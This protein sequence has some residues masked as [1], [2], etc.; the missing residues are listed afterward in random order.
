MKTQHAVV[1]GLAM[2]F[3]ALLY[4]W[5]LYPAL[6]DRIPVHWNIHGQVDGWAD[7]RVAI[8]LMPGVMALLVGMLVAL[9]WLSP[10]N[11]AIE[12]FGGTF[13]AMLL[14]C[15]ALVGF[16]HGVM[17]QA[18]LHPEMDSGRVL[19]IG[20][21]VF[22]ALLGSGLGR[23]RRNFWIGIRT[24]WTLASDAVWDATHRLAARVLVATGILGALGMGL[25]LPVAVSFTLLLLAPLVPIFY[26]LWLSKRLERE[27][28][29]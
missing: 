2:A 18:A 12:P 27:D 29:A 5:I 24:P 21:F 14:L 6:P 20:L 16:V 22:F 10:R 26:S 1:A 28:Q 7:K 19:V 9:P 4:A 8:Y 11:F 25:G 17:L 13:N 23:V 15:T 3:T